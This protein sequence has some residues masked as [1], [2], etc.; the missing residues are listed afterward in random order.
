MKVQLIEYL[1]RLSVI[2]GVLL[3]YYQFFMASNHHWRLRRFYLLSTYLLGI[4]IPLLPS[5]SWSQMPETLPSLQIGTALSLSFEA[6]I[7]GA[8]EE[9]QAN[10]SLWFWLAVFY[11]LGVLLQV[12]FL[13]KNL[14]QIQRWKARGSNQSFGSYRIIEHRTIPSPFAGWRTIFL[15][16]TIERDLHAIACLHEAAHLKSHH[17]Q[18][19]LPLI[20]GQVFLWFHP[21]QW[22]YI[23]CLNTVQEFQADEAV[24][25]HVPTKT[26]GHILIQQSMLPTHS[27]QAGLFASPLKQRIYMMTRQKNKQAWRLPQMSIFLVLLGLLIFGC[28]DIMDTSPPNY[29]HLLSHLEVDQAPILLGS[30][31]TSTPDQAINRSFLEKVYRNIKYPASARN[32][33][34]EGFAVAGFIIDEQGKLHSLSFW[35][36]D[37]NYLVDKQGNLSHTNSQSPY[38]KESDDMEEIVITGYGTSQQEPA[39]SA[40][41]MK[42]L[43]EEIA[44]VLSEL[45]DWTPAQ[46]DGKVVPVFMDLAFRFKLE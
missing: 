7:S 4:C 9:A 12:I 11:L 24:L 1:L 3:L 25:Q 42:V 27:W 2:W 34:L 38:I 15:P 16:T 40:S 22:Y 30:D 31:V 36:R 6:P 32:N 20:I 44:R 29:D 41:N 17:N 33:G 8:K 45:P 43:L 26:Y 13:L 18:E 46:K 14:W 10:F 19:R 35:T 23:H 5:L 37:G 21:L 28:S 39:N